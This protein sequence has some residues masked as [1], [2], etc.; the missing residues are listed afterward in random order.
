MFYLTNLSVSF[1]IITCLFFIFNKTDLYFRQKETPVIKGLRT[2]Y[3]VGELLNVNCSTTA[4]DAQLKWYLNDEQINSNYLIPYTSLYQTNQS[5]S[6]SNQVASLY[7]S[8]PHQLTNIY[9][10]NGL[11]HALKRRTFSIQNTA[12]TDNQRLN[13]IR[14]S[15]ASNNNNH[16]ATYAA[17]LNQLT[18]SLNVDENQILGLQMPLQQHHFQFDFKLKCVAIM[19]KQVPFLDDNF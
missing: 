1:T 19:Y 6:N 10:N 14:R 17:H 3:R 15:L 18:N 5:I 11:A 2:S 9:Y 16:H 13:G 12:A 7:E 8:L 4:R